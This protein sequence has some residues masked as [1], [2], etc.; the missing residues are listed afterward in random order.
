MRYG[1]F[2]RR[3]AVD[4]NVLCTRS[5][6]ERCVRRRLERWRFHGAGG[7]QDQRREPHAPGRRQPPQ[8]VAPPCGGLLTPSPTGPKGPRPY[9]P[10]TMADAPLPDLILYGRPGCGLCDEARELIHGAA[11]RAPPDGS[12]GPRPS[13]SSTSRPIPAW[14][15]PTSRRSRSSSSAIDASSSRPAPPSCAA[16]SATSSTRSRRPHDR[17]HRSHDPRR[18]SRP[19]VIS[20]L[21]PCVLPLVPAYLGQT[22]GDRRRRRADRYADRGRAGWPSATPSRTSPASAASSRS[23]A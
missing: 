5:T 21:S 19:G 14:N 10:S 7:S 13:S 8:A 18:R 15:A 22:D 2:E 6:L 17:R 1:P 4:W 12:A 3:L 16:S 23:S 20:F 11:G 9:N